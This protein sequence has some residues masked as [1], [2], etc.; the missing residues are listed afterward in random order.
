[1]E[2]RELI[3]SVIEKQG[4]T[5]QVDDDGDV[6]IYYQMKKVF[7]MFSDD[8]ENYL[9]VTCPN[10][11]EVEEGGEALALAACNKATREL[12]LV[13]MYTDSTMSYVSAS[14]EFYYDSEQTL[15]MC[16]EKSLSVLGVA[17]TVYRN[18]KAELDS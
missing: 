3:L 8:A 15:A 4:Y 2:K 14:C 1:M 7:F 13:K 18:T 5:P 9:V 12:K 11:S 16:V 10:V 6:Y 17:R